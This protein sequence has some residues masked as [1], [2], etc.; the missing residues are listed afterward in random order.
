MNAAEQK[1]FEAWMASLTKSECIRW[2][3]RQYGSQDHP[4]FADGLKQWASLAKVDDE[5]EEV[6]EAADDSLPEA[7][8]PVS[9]VVAAPEPEP[10]PDPTP[11]PEPEPAPDEDGEGS[12]LFESEEDLN[13]G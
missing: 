6:A 10:E 8:S 13:D 1:K 2:L 5:P 11:E 4:K 7:E 12:G 3:S 9:D